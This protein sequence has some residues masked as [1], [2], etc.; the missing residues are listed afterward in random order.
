MEEFQFCEVYLGKSKDKLDA[1]DLALPFEDAI[2][3]FGHFLKYVVPVRLPDDIFR[4]LMYL[5]DPTPCS[6]GRYINH[7]RKSLGKRLQK[8]SFNLYLLLL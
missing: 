8:T 4:G 1:I 6:D 3:I 2:V 7:L 5:P